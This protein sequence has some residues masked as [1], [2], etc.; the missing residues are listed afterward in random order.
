[1]RTPDLILLDLKMPGMSARRFISLLKDRATW[2]RASI[3]LVTGASQGDIPT[4][5]QVDALLPKPFSIERLLEVVGGRA[6]H[7]AKMPNSNA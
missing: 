4:D 1:M 3:I 6:H 7:A 2:S 5:L